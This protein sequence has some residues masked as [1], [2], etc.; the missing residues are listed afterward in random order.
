[1]NN[2]NSAL[3]PDSPARAAITAAGWEIAT[4]GMEVVL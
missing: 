3:M 2:T 1:V 4:D